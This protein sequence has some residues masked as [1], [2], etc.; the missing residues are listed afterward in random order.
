MNLIV[1]NLGSENKNLYKADT[2][3]A[4]Q[5]TRVLWVFID[6]KY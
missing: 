2:W 5:K 3:M 4:V 6:L 1:G